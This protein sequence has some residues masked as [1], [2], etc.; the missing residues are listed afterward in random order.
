MNTIVRPITPDGNVGFDEYGQ[1]CCWRNTERGTVGTMIADMRDKK[2]G[3]CAQPWEMTAEGFSNQQYVRS[4]GEWVHETCWVGYLGMKESFMWYELLCARKTT[5]EWTKIP[6]E[7]GGAY[8]TPWFKVTFTGYV[9]WMKIGSRKRVFHMSLHDLSARQCAEFT[10]FE[11]ENVTKHC[12]GRSIMIH[13]W[14]EADAANYLKEF[15][16]I[17]QTEP[18]KK[19]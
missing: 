16:E 11:K 14:A 9:P 5:W 7:Y 17:V 12:D 10:R 4:V 6:N 15:V 18:L 3:L 1:L 2:C 19:D 8:N 13:A